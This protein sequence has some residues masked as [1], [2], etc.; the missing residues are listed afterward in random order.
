MTEPVLPDRPEG[1]SDAA[2]SEERPDDP[3]E[4]LRRERPPHHDRWQHES[5]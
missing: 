2:W 3:D 4:R 1:E 5:D